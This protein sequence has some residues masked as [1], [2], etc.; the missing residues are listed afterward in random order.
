MKSLIIASTAFL[1]IF[2]FSPLSAQEIE[3]IGSIDSIITTCSVVVDGDYAYLA[4]DEVSLRIVDISDPAAPRVIG[5][6]DTPGDGIAVSLYENN[7]F[8]LDM[9]SGLYVIDI[10][11][12]EN[13]VVTGSYLIQEWTSAMYISRGYAYISLY[14]GDTLIIL[15][16][17][18]PGDPRLVGEFSPTQGKIFVVGHI[19]YM[20]HGF[21]GFF[22]GCAGAVEIL[23]A[24]DP[25]S[26]AFLGSY[27][28]QW[29]PCL[30]I[31]V[32]DNLGYLATG[33]RY[34]M[35]NFGDFRI[36]DVGDP[37][38]VTEI[39]WYSDH[40]NP[41]IYIDVFL[42]GDYAYLLCESGFWG[43]NLQ[44]VDVSDPTD[45][46]SMAEYDFHTFVIDSYVAGDF[47]Y[48]AGQKTLI[49]LRFNPD[50]DISD[51]ESNPRSFSLSQNHPN[52]F[53]SS[54]TISYDLPRRSDVRI[55]IYDILG[56]RIEML[57][58]GDQPAGT[59]SV[60]WDARDASSGIYFYRIK[61]GDFAASKS[62]L[63][64]K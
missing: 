34:L 39:G 49:I 11:S 26:P 18:D 45:P 24:A 5:T 48:V 4:G 53:N 64:L 38:D 62:C 31:V 16:V 37:S 3:Y 9:N 44:I 60:V 10:S 59:H 30:D 27:N 6:L 22:Y 51:E 63:L 33:G 7:C 28:S 61:A 15:D 29:N 36:L 46:A 23:D 2:A 19:I 35:Q 13:P 32:R 47:I 43:D 25:S 12:P 40:Y 8:L 52:P 1:M 21:C 42:Q 14:S 57:L 20:P 17:N 41:G 50:T 56:R 55:E 54:T 58:N